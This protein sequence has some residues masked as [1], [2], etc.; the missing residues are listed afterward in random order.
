MAGAESLEA[1]YLQASSGVPLPEHALWSI[2]IQLSSALRA[3]HAAGF[4]ARSVD[5]SKVPAS[6]LVPL[7]DSANFFCLGAPN[8][9]PALVV[10]RADNGLWGNDQV[11][12]ATS[13]GRV[14][15]KLGAVGLLDLVSPESVHD[16]SHFQREDLLALGKLILSLAC[17]SALALENVSD[18]LEYVTAQYSPDV[19]HASLLFLPLG[20][21]G[22][23]L[24]YCLCPRAL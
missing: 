21:S 11:L 7:L 19:R 15:V 1:R 17:R 5:S 8:V 12:V 4:A 9:R 6:P 22:I 23:A 16:V 10:C 20:T 3:I 13:A 18:A 14:R 2:F 24:I